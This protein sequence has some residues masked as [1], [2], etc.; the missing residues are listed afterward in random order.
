[1]AVVGEDK[2]GD[3]VRD[4]KK[5]DYGNISISSSAS[6]TSTLKPPEKP[7]FAKMTPKA[8]VAAQKRYKQDMKAYQK[9]KKAET[10]FKLKERRKE[11]NRRAIR[12]AGIQYT[13]NITTTL[14]TMSLVQ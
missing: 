11:A 14:R 1:M 7:N 12:R 4:Q 9:E 13:G 6:T 10:N 2:G 5:T 8:K 3:K